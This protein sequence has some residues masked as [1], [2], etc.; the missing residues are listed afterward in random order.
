MGRRFSCAI[1]EGVRVGAV[2]A[3]LLWILMGIEGAPAAD[4]FFGVRKLLEA[5]GYPSTPLETVFSGIGTPIYSNVALSMKIR[6]SAL[7][8]QAF[9]QPAVLAQAEDFWNAHEKAL[10]RAG[11]LYGV[12]PSVIV[13]VLLV[14]TRLGQNTGSHPVAATLATFALMLD[15]VERDRVWRM[16]SESDRA[17]WTRS[18]FDAKME[19]RASWALKELR[20]LL[21]LVEKGYTDAAQWRGSYMAAVGWPQF[22]PSSLLHYGADGD[23]DGIVDLYCPADA[24]ASIARYLKLNGW[25]ND[26][27]WEQQE[28]VILRYNNSRPYAETIL[29]AARRLRESR[30]SARGPASE[31]APR[32]EA[33]AALK[34]SS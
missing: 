32:T 19:Q 7:N 17:R 9:L 26:A 30:A 28:K 11:A 14:E 10:R 4:P 29:E 25:E 24:F 6:E 15:P 13:A 33:P 18:R 1:R 22:L 8:Y 20:A 27:P 5:E 3:V 2:A 16:L 12:D 21:T 23:G 34:S 31:N